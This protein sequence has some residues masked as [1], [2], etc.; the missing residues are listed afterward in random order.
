M[1]NGGFFAS[2]NRVIYVSIGLIYLLFLLWVIINTREFV[3]VGSEAYWYK[4]FISYAL[5]NVLILGSANI[6]NKLFNIQLKKFIPIYL[7]FFV[8]FLIFFWFILTIFNPIQQSAFSLL[9]GVPVWLAMSHAFIFATTET[10]FFQG[11]LDGAIGIPASP[12]VAG[13]FHLFIWS[14][15][16]WVVIIGAT[17][18][19]LFFSFV[20]WY[21][22]TKGFFGWIKGTISN[23][24]IATMACHGAFNAVQLG[25]FVSI[26][27]VL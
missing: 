16:W 17:A 2:W 27:G 5:L 19:F 24:L 20:N 15:A 1:S 21:I 23:G 8:G 14:G 12:I 18:L 7:I 11:Y 25:L 13:I 3:P 9:A 6:R 10:V 26:G 4:V 22:R